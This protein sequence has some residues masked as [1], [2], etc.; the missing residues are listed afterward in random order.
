MMEEDRVRFSRVRPPKQNDVGVFNFT[1][2][3]CSASCSEYGRQTGDAGGVSSAIAAV[4]VI[5]PHD[6]ANEFLCCI[7]QFVRRLGTTE[8]PKIPRIAFFDGSAK[9]RGSAVQGLIPRSRA[10]QA[11]VAHQRLGKAGCHWFNHGGPK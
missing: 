11:V 2:R 10:M 5:R 9:Y 4:D 3:T 1:V 8:H 6:A 7:V